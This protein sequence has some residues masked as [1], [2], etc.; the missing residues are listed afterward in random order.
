MKNKVICIS[1][2][3]IALSSTAYAQDYTQAPMLDALV[4]QGELPP[5]EQ[6][7]PT[8]PLVVEPVDSIGVYGGTWRSGLRG[9]NDTAWIGRTVAYDGLLRYQRDSRVIIPNLA[10][11]WEVSEDARRYSFKLREGLLWSDGSP[12]TSADVEFAVML[13]QDPQYPA[14]FGSVSSTANPMTIEI[15]DATAFTLVFEEPNGLLLDELASINGFQIASF[16]KQYCGQFYPGVNPDAAELAQ[17]NGFETWAEYLED[18]C[19]WFVERERWANPELPMMTA[20]VVDEPLSPTSTRVTFE[21]NPYYWKVDTENQQLPYID[22][23]EMRISESIEELTLMALGGE[24]DFQDRHINTI[25][26]QPLF[27][28]GQEEGDY[29]LGTS[30]SASSNTMVL[31]LNLNHDDPQ[32]RQLFQSREFRIGL[33]HAIDRQEIVDVV[34]TGQGRP[35]QMAP[36]PESVFYD[37]EM[38]TQYTEVDLDRAEELFQEAGLVKNESTGYYEFEDGTPFELTIDSIAAYQPQWVDVLELIQI[39]LDQV[40][41]QM[42]VNN[43]DRSLYYDKRPGN[44]F[45]AQIWEGSSIDF[46][47]DPRHYL[48]ANPESVWAYRWQAWYNGTM[49]EIAEEPVDWAKEQME[50]YNQV[51]SEADQ[52]RRESLM[53][54]ILEITKEQFPVIGISL[55]P[56]GYYVARN[57]L[58]NVLEPMLHAYISPTP[59]SYEP[60]QWYFARD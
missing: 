25:N 35:F 48:A 54:E 45:D 1:L 30:V 28:D 9:G 16:N 21:R 41:I 55:P 24:I 31:M 46:M 56:N 47:Q 22:R 20:W 2:A 50:L 33:S 39:Q 43:I 58:R 40:G 4:E 6:R 37:E 60:Y 27:F 59:A 13:L 51:R 3:A 18:R 23:L 15:E 57:E 52:D 26:N 32:K 19:A 53:R 10:E 29:R 49:P 38:A 7:L 8:N 17:A 5:V 44:Q 36:R 42:Q 14:T 11:S 12:F 34:Y